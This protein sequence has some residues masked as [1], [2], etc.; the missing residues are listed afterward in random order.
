MLKKPTNKSS[1]RFLV[2]KKD[3]KT[4]KPLKKH[5]AGTKRYELH[6]L[7]KKTLGNGAVTVELLKQAVKLPT[8]EDLNEWL[9]VHGMIRGLHSVILLIYFFP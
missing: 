9:A 5:Q 1:P 3:R 7:A 2:G 6:K 4:I 8:G